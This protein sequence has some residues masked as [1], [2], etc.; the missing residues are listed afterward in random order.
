MSGCV[1]GCVIV[2]VGAVAGVFQVWV[3]CTCV[4]LLWSPAFESRLGT[5]ANEA[6]SALRGDPSTKLAAQTYRWESLTQ[7]GPAGLWLCVWSS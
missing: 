5:Q 7:E 2:T 1:H 3:A 4:C 6:N